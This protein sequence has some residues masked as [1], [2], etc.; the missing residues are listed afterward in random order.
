MRYAIFDLDGTLVESMI[1][2]RGFEKAFLLENGIK[3]ENIKKLSKE[4]WIGSDWIEVLC[5]F[6]NKEY[7]FDLT[8]EK[9][10]QWGINFMMRK[11]AEDVQFKPGAKQLLDKFLSEGVKMCICSSTDRAIMEPLLQRFNLDR[12]FQFTIHCRQFGMEKN[13]PEIFMHCMRELG[14]EKPSEV[15][16]FEDA[17]Y[18]ASTAKAAG[19]YTVAMYD[20]T[21]KGEKQLKELA[22]QYVTDYAQLDYSKLPE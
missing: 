4:Q 20:V 17:L 5:E 3:E 14:A 8:P 1:Y 10:H 7:G 21:E 12:Y 13:N 19:F 11:Y 18:S 6:F 15:A 22:D 16:V 2:W 9:F